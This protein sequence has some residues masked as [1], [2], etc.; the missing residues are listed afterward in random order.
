MTRELEVT[1]TAQDLHRIRRTAL[2]FNLDGGG[3]Y[4]CSHTA[5][6]V[7]A[8]EED[9]PQCWDIP[10]SAGCLDHPASYVGYLIWTPRNSAYRLGVGINPYDLVEERRRLK[11]RDLNDEE[12]TELHRWLR[13]KVQELLNL[14]ALAPYVVGLRCP[15]CTYLLPW[16]APLDELMDHVLSQHGDL[17]VS[18]FRLDEPPQLITPKGNILLAVE[19]SFTDP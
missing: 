5:I 9:R 2:A 17:K 7:W 16:G 14:A 3:N 19:E 1:A 11:K 8:V 12:R 6:N 13:R 10:M 15:A 18:G 4:E